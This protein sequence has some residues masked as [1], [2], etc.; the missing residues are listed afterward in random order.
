MII[1]LVLRNIYRSHFP[2]V[3]SMSTKTPFIFLRVHRDRVL[4]K[5]HWNPLDILVPLWSENLTF[6]RVYLSQKRFL[7]CDT[8]YRTIPSHSPRA[9][10]GAR[11]WASICLALFRALKEMMTFEYCSSHTDRV[12]APLQHVLSPIAFSWNIQST[13]KKV[14]TMC[15]ISISESHRPVC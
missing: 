8:P 12:L 10:F 6:S 15:E 14:G 3:N 1:V 2:K 13:T 7:S 11:C 4:A 9:G 5:L